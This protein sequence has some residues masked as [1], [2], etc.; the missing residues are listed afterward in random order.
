MKRGFSIAAVAALT[1]ALAA[2]DDNNDRMAA[3]GKLCASWKTPAAASDPNSPANAAALQNGLAPGG[4]DAA[5]PVDIC[6]KRWAY[7]LAGSRDS[8]DVVAD[9]AVAACAPALSNWNQSTMGQG[10]GMNGASAPAISTVTGQPTNA[11]AEHADFARGRALLYVV[12]AR[13]GQCKPPPVV[14]GAPAGA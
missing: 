5:S 9:A 13:A 6:V 3:N 12:E 10:G 1:F 4:G 8:A 7:S 11:M 14:N 2:C